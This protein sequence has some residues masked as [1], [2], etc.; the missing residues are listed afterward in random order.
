[1][2]ESYDAVIVGA[3][4]N[5]LAAA[6]VLAGEGLSVLVLEANDTIGGGA[7]TE[8]LTLPG[9]HHDVCSAIHPMGVLS[10]FFREIGLSQTGVGA[11]LTWIQPPVSLAHPLEDGGADGG[12]AGIADGGGDAGVA[13][14]RDLEVTARG[15]G[16]ADA[17]MW[18]AMHE[19]R[20][21]N[22]DRFFA[23]TLRPIRIP[24][25]P[26]AMA[27]FGM[28]AVQ[29]AERVAK[30]WFRGTRARAVFAGCAA[31][32]MMPLDRAGTAAFG[33]MLSLSVHA[34]G[35][36]LPRGGS[37][38]II[39][40]MAKKLV[41][42][43]GVVR[44]GE[45][46]RSLAQLPRARAVLFDVM[47]QSFASIAGDALPASYKRQLMRY[48]YGPGVFKLDWALD[49]PIPWR[50]A[51]ARRAG[52]V[53]VGPTLE[54]IMRSEKAAW[55]GDVCDAPFV[56]VAQQSL[57]DDTRAPRGKHTGWAYCHV[58]NGSTVD[59]TS[60]IEAQIERFAPG[61]KDLI[62]ARHAMSAVDVETHSGGSFV[63]GDIGGGASTLLQ[64]LARPVLRW[65]PYTTP[66]P[67]LFLAS[68]ATPPG[69][70]VHGMCGFWAATAALERVFGRSR[71]RVRVRVS[72]R[73]TNDDVRPAR[74]R[75]EQTTF[76]QVR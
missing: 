29:S 44:T 34:A 56:L 48:R 45:R 17:F 67:R 76:E 6:L 3:G 30:S 55:D 19:A 39:D 60:R 21:R 13:L 62:L 66:N 18:R 58:P 12:A 49:G 20:L 5:G 53:H 74:A 10:P 40:V 54:D 70:G 61:F 68:S 75:E 28:T 65:N 36:P 31:H 4:P 46:V 27:A 14:V 41:E 32:S 37:R 38:A 22:A 9:F 26:F 16:D 59:M 33:M 57:F 35:W 47:P 7:R 8:E 43:G 50:D 73:E 63:G 42:L 25:H 11:P 1:M 15:L 23:D 51:A 52:T 64:F 24:R 72:T 2:A 71:G 69:G